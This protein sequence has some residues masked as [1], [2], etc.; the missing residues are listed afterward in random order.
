LRILIFCLAGYFISR[1]IVVPEGENNF[2][3]RIILIAEVFKVVEKIVS[4]SFQRFF[5]IAR[6]IEKIGEGKPLLQR[7]KGEKKVTEQHY[8]YNK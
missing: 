3:L 7:V 4:E 2:V 1:I 6:R 5:S 8:C